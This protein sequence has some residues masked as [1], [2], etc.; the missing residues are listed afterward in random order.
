MTDFVVGKEVLS[1][2][3]KCKLPLGHMIMAMKD[4]KTIGKVQCLTCK[5]MHGYK[6]PS[7]Q[8]AKKSTTAKAKGKSKGRQPEVSAH[9][10]WLTAVDKS[11]T[12]MVTY[13]PKTKF[14]V[15]D[16]IDHSTFGPGVVERIIDGNKIEVVFRHE[17]KTLIH[18]VGN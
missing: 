16:K 1:Y 17:I 6:D 13:S 10:R 18:D 3:A 14:V 12:K 8:K 9:D 15:G 2:C 7:L 4:P 11:T 5:S